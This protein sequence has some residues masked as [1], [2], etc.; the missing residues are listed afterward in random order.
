MTRKHKNTLP[1]WLRRTTRVTWATCTKIYSESMKITSEI[2]YF[3]TF[4]TIDAMS[5]MLFRV[6]DILEFGRQYFH[7]EK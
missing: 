3:F 2:E 7:T 6:C 5:D 1:G 4:S